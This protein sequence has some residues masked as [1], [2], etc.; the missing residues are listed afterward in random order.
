MAAQSS[1]H[2]WRGIL[3]AT[4]HNTANNIAT[5]YLERVIL[6]SCNN[7]A[8]LAT[9]VLQ[10]CRDWASEQQDCKLS[11]PQRLEKAQRTPDG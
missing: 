7:T 10:P 8:I 11:H 4:L 9:C 2:K 5:L 1:E 3:I 6:Q